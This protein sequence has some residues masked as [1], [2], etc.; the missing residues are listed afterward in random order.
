MRGRREQPAAIA[1]GRD[2]LRPRIDQPEQVFRRCARREV[3]QAEADEVRARDELV[4]GGVAPANDLADDERAEH[5]LP[6]DGHKG[7]VRRHRRPLRNQLVGDRK[8]E[9]GR[10]AAPGVWQCR[11]RYR[12]RGREAPLDPPPNGLDI[13][14][15]RP[16]VESREHDLGACCTEEVELPSLRRDR[17][18]SDQ[19]PDAESQPGE[20]EGPVC[21][22]ATEA[23]ASWIV[24]REVAGGSAD[25]QRDRVIG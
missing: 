11:D 15:D 19:R 23:P 2:E 25:D 24:G 12:I 5:P 7:G 18:D 21:D 4:S 14:E 20:G 9:P 22:R 10:L 3:V 8:E 6:T 17:I 16:V 1:L 13:L